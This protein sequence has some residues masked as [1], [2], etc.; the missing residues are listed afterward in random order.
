MK[1]GRREAGDLCRVHGTVLIVRDY[2]EVFG[3]PHGE[4][5]CPICFFGPIGATLRPTI[6]P[7]VGSTGDTAG[8]EQ[9]ANEG[10]PDVSLGA[11]GPSPLEKDARP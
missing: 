6:P 2:A 3:M 9:A 8:H 1:D 7:A 11:R 5:F 10:A 4:A